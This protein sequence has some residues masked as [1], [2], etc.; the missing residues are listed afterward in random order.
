LKLLQNHIKN[1]FF[2]HLLRP[3]LFAEREDDSDEDFTET[4]ANGDDEDDYDKALFNFQPMLS[5]FNSEETEASDKVFWDFEKTIKL[6]IFS[7]Q[8]SIQA[9]GGQQPEEPI[10]V[11]NAISRRGGRLIRRQNGNERQHQNH[12]Y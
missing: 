7:F 3:C 9:L 2:S 8:P 10:T 4:D 12:L 11:H 1:I 6:K 5:G